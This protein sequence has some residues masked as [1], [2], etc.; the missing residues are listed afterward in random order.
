MTKKEDRGSLLEM[1]C[2]DASKRVEEEK[3][4]ESETHSDVFVVSFFVS[5]YSDWQRHT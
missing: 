5:E 4:K 2:V 3:R 1:F